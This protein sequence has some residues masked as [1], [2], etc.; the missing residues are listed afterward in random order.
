[1]FIT[2]SDIADAL[3]TLVA[4]AF[5][6]EKIYRELTER[7]FSR[8]CTLI[9]QKGCTGDVDVGS[10]IV[11]L[12]PT[13]TLTTFVKVDPYHN[14][15]LADLHLRQMRLVG[16]FL[17][18][19]IRVK[20]R[21]PKVHGVEMGGGYDYDT[22]TVTFRYTLDRSDF[23]NIPQLPVMEQLHTNEEEVETYG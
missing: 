17:A 18:G 19:F 1:M 12:R 8:P 23:M 9:V 15:H 10:N 14:S 11:E 7:D 13:F 16:L 4:A 22:V 3:E 5:P 20:D 6:D 21:G 2:P